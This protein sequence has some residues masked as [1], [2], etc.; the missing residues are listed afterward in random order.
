MYQSIHPLHRSVIRQAA[1]LDE[2][3][4]QIRRRHGDAECK[5][6]SDWAEEKSRT[7]Q[8]SYFDWLEVG[9]RKLMFGEVLN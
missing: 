5:R 4:H 2:R 6:V 9:E 8:F 1:N 7:T 3:L